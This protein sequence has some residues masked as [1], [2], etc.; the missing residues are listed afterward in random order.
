MAQIL[1]DSHSTRLSPKT[2]CV[3]GENS[4]E[5][6][7][8]EG[9]KNDLKLRYYSRCMRE[10]FLSFGMA[11]SK[12]THDMSNK[13]LTPTYPEV[14]HQNTLNLEPQALLEPYMLTP[15]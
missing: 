2:T 15:S 8:T 10:E 7:P 11:P 1:A 6:V 3:S 14:F 12:H 13:Y 9:P 4:W 5:V